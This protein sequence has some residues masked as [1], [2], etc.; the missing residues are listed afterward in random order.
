MEGTHTPFPAYLKLLPEMLK[1]WANNSN[2]S[3][4]KFVMLFKWLSKYKPKLMYRQVIHLGYTDFTEADVQRIVAEM[5]KEF[6]YLNTCLTIFG[7]I[8]IYVLQNQGR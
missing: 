7:I 5:G 8:L 4:P 2:S 6:R 3:T 1:N